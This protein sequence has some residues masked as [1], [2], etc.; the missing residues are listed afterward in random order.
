M[1]FPSVVGPGAKIKHVS[2]YNAWLIEYSA[3]GKPSEC[4]VI[5]DTKCPVLYFKDAAR[6][7]DMVYQAPKEQMKTVNYNVAGVTPSR[8]AKEIELIVRKYIPEA[9]ISYKPDPEVM[10]YYRTV[11]VDVF[12]DR[13]AREEWGWQPMYQDFDK[14]VVDFIEEIRVRPERYGIA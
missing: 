13:R 12:N 1:R 3:L 9:Q 14:L 2:Q 11:R 6:A 4:F 5:E 8:T 7:V 10:D